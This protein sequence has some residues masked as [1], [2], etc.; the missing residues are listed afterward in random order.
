MRTYR[1]GIRLIQ[2]SAGLA[3]IVLIAGFF[4]VW[5]ERTTEQESES[6]RD[7]IPQETIPWSN[8]KIVALGDSFTQ[9]YP[10]EESQSW[11][12]RLAD[13]LHVEVVNKGKGQQTSSDLLAR[14]EADVIDENPGRVIIFAGIG[15]A[16][17]EVPLEDTKASIQAMVEKA[18]EA[19]IVP[20][21]ALPISY[22]GFQ[23]SITATRDWEIEYALIEGIIT[24]DFSEVLFDED[25]KF[26]S[27]LVSSNEKYPNAKG[28]E[29]MGDY[30]AQILK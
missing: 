1:I 21:L 24:I 27:T 25:G 30:A 9:G 23:Q 14:F 3:L 6:P 16:I 8:P 12:K 7:P 20:I 4:G 15:D 10:L 28:Y 26:I 5:G 2:L 19:K 29:K 17:Q 18:K 22:Q 11:P 13:V